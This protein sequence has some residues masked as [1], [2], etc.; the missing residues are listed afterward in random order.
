VA[1]ASAYFRFGVSADVAQ[2][3]YARLRFYTPLIEADGRVSR[4]RFSLH[5]V[6]H[7]L[8][9]FLNSDLETW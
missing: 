3:P 4:I 8:L 7:S 1:K 5:F 6:M 9:E 2:K